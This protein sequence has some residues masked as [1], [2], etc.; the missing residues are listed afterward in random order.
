MQSEEEEENISIIET[1]R[2]TNFLIED[3]AKDDDE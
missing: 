3:H 1:N 2:E